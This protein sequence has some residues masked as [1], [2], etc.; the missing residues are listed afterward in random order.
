MNLEV[1]DISFCYGERKIL[2]DISFSASSGNMLAILGRN[3]S[4]KTT[5]LR[6]LLGFLKPDKGQ[7]LIDSRNIDEM[8]KSLSSKSLNRYKSNFPE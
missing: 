5:L 4:G 3:G 1:K 7:I 8:T 6:L 2:E